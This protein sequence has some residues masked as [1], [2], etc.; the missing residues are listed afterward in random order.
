[1]IA[2]DMDRFRPV[3]TRTITD[4]DGHSPHDP[5]TG[6]S[7]PAAGRR[8]AG[9]RSGAAARRGRRDRLSVRPSGDVPAPDDRGLCA[10]GDAHSATRAAVWHRART[11]QLGHPRSRDPRALHGRARPAAGGPDRR[12]LLVDYRGHDRRDGAGWSGWADRATDR[13]RHRLRRPL[14]HGAGLVPDAGSRR[15]GLA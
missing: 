11:G 8:R 12:R 14:R 10:D 15:V 1:M 4:D 3:Q 5:Q 7:Q 9:S 6:G 2:S 13:H